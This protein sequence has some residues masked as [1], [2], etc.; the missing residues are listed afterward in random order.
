MS[1]NKNGLLGDTFSIPFVLI[2]VFVIVVLFVVVSGIIGGV[3]GFGESGKV[4]NYEE[5]VLFEK[6]DV[7]IDGESRNFFVFEAMNLLEQEKISSDS[8]VESLKGLIDEEHTC[9]TISFVQEENVEYYLSLVFLRLLDNG[10]IYEDIDALF[11]HRRYR[12]VLDRVFAFYDEQSGQAVFMDY[13][14]GLCR[15][16]LEG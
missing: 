7:E 9:L 8:L 16:D 12:S 2:I 5:S 13:Y 1:M 15:E 6:V 14:Y 4:I 11:Y 3:D 10:D